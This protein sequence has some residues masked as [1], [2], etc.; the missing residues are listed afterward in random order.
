MSSFEIHKNAYKVHLRVDSFEIFYG[1]D[2]MRQGL[3]FDVYEG[4]YS[5]GG[6]IIFNDLVVKIGN[7]FIFKKLI[8]I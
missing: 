1:G 2:S 6:K 3:S 7:H 4:I 5:Q 8:Y